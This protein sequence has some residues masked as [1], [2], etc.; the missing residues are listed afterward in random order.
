M[1]KFC[2]QTASPLPDLR[3]PPDEVLSPS[4]TIGGKKQA[5]SRSERSTGSPVLVNETSICVTPPAR[6]PVTSSER[7]ECGISSRDARSC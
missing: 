1:A 2:N 7:G 4:L 6:A 5:R 3:I